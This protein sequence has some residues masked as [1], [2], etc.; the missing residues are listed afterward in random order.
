MERL[1]EFKEERCEWFV[2]REPLAQ[3]AYE[4]REALC[5]WVVRREPLAEV[6]RPFIGDRC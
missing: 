5:M 1:D 4:S 2:R 3:V 6:I